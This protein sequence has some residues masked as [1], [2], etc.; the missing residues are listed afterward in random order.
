MERTIIKEEEVHNRLS[1]HV[2][3]EYNHR[4]DI[5]IDKCFTNN[6]IPETFFF[7]SGNV[8]RIEFNNCTIH[9]LK[10]SQ[11]NIRQMRYI[12]C[13]IDYLL[14]SHVVQNGILFENCHIQN[15][16]FD[17][18]LHNVE[19]RFINCTGLENVKGIPIKQSDE[20]P[21]DVFKDRSAMTKINYSGKE[22]YYGECYKDKE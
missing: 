15:L 5:A 1:N 12:D 8:D 4:Y 14:F 16:V 7:L 13:D 17:E 20:V 2:D 6:I 22:F 18:C 19:V 21:M 3:W 11:G 9:S 10:W